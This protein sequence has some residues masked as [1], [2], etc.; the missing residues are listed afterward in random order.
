[1]SG[2]PKAAKALSKASQK[3]WALGGCLGCGGFMLLA[4]VMAVVGFKRSIE[5]ANVWGQLS[6]YMSFEDPP[7]GFEPLFVVS[8]FDQRQVAFYRASDLTEVIVMEF[9]GRVREGF[10]D[11]FDVDKLAA[12]GASEVTEGVLQLQ[13]HEVPFVTFVGGAAAGS[14]AAAR[15]E[16]RDGLQGTLLEALGLLPD[17][18]PVFPEGTPIMHLRFSGA[19]DS[20]GTLLIVRAPTLAVPTEAELE[21][22]FAP[23]D[24]W[25][26]VGSAP[27]PPVN[28]EEL[29]D[30]R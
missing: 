13:G 26:R 10:E 15:V 5:P 3:R 19:A 25:S 18:P 28:P 16:Q 20:G 12:E 11:A 17:E 2:T 30:A 14:G 21:A 7:E 27:L 23:F 29:P 9:T 22:L 6:A 1:M 24:L 4:V 8:F